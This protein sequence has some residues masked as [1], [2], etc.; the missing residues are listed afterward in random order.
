MPGEL[1]SLDVGPLIHDTVGYSRL[2]TEGSV[3]VVKT[4]NNW[5]ENQ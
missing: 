4:A 3:C 1:N 5:L 2:E